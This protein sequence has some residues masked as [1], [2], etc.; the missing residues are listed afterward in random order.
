MSQLWTD[1][2]AHYFIATHYPW[3]LDT[4][5]HYPYPIQRADAIRYF[6]LSHLGGIYIDMDDVALP[7][8]LAFLLAISD[9]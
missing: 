1:R 8:S 6:I 2:T 7:H 9:E 5:E 4:F 3:F